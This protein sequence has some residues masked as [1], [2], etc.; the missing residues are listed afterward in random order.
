M[1]S[2]LKV[3]RFNND[4]TVNT[5]DY[6]TILVAPGAIIVLVVVF[7]RKGGFKF[8]K[9]S[10]ISDQHVQVPKEPQHVELILFEHKTC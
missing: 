9:D 5:L 6:R 8:A 2:Q 4:E 7:N 10:Q 1:L 3:L